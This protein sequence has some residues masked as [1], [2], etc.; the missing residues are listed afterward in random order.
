MWRSGSHWSCSARSF[1][2]APTS[3][4]WPDT[5]PTRLTWRWWWICCEIRAKIF[6]SK[7]STCSRF[8]S[9]GFTWVQRC[10]FMYNVI[11]VFVANPKKPPQI[12][13]ILRRNKEKLLNF[14]KTFHNDKEGTSVSHLTLAL[15]LKIIFEQMNNSATRSNSWLCKSRICNLLCTS[16]K[17]NHLRCV[18][19]GSLLGTSLAPSLFSCGH[20]SSLCCYRRVSSL[21]CYTFPSISL[22]SSLSHPRQC[23]SPSHRSIALSGSLIYLAGKRPAQL[24]RPRNET[25]HYVIHT[26]QASSFTGSREQQQQR[27]VA[28]IL[29]LHRI[30]E[31]AHW[32]HHVHHW[33]D[34]ADLVAHS[35]VI[36]VAAIWLCLDGNHQILPRF[37]GYLYTLYMNQLYSD[38]IINATMNIVLNSNRQQA[39]RLLRAEQSME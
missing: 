6:S 10:L 35:N 2:T 34:G 27:F 16:C 37:A 3:A 33:H 12:E 30:Y 4:W 32:R 21:D 22:S 25:V 9:V 7:H 29:A 24:Y 1:W 17:A 28:R 20:H 38:D 5:L 36:L 31:E 14:L 18:Y 11:Q 13:S 15:L 23:K 26:S 8:V 39:D 19:S